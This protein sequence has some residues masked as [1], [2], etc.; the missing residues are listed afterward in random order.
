VRCRPI[1][2]R[3]EKRCR[4]KLLPPMRCGTGKGQVAGCGVAPTN[5]MCVTTEILGIKYIVYKSRNYGITFQIQN[6]CVKC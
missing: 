2:T 5:A 3:E 1:T 4:K 6:A